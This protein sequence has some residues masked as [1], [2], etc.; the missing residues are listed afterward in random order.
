M[1]KKKRKE[2]PSQEAFD[3][4]SSSKGYF[5]KYKKSLDEDELQQKV[6]VK[7]AKGGT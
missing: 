7:D 4:K 1:I 6:I 2:R 3:N 5:S